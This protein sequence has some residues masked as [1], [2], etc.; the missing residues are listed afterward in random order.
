MTGWV[1]LGLVL[2]L[3]ALIGAA[4][5]LAL[6]S[7][8]ARSHRQTRRMLRQMGNQTIP[9]KVVKYSAEATPNTSP[10][11]QVDQPTEGE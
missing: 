6:M 9:T 5:V 8:L 11:V 2:L 3:Y 1:A 4:V 10:K 7:P